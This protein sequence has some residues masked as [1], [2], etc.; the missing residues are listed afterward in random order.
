V[1]TPA[2]VLVIRFSRLLHVSASG[3]FDCSS[4]VLW[5]SRVLRLYAVGSRN[6]RPVLLSVTWNHA[7]PRWF[8]LLTLWLRDVCLTPGSKKVTTHNFTLE[9]SPLV[10]RQ[11][12][13]FH[14]FRLKTKYTEIKLFHGSCPL[15]NLQSHVC[16]T[17]TWSHYMSDVPPRYRVI[18]SKSFNALNRIQ[19]FRS[20]T[21]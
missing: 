5:L 6:S 17:K 9:R 14:T 13:S 1:L 19:N 3:F 12:V 2:Y 7:V 18:D 8:M 16:N 11:M 10:S 4:V 21:K 15:Q 20:V